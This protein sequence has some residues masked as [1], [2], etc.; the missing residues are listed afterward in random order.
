MSMRSWQQTVG[1]MG[2]LMSLVLIGQFIN[3]IS[4]ELLII[5]S[6]MFISGILFGYGLIVPI[7][8]DVEK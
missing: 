4:V 6:L 7:K 1:L 8:K 3:F 2:F 5:F